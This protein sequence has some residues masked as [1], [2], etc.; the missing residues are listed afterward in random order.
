MRRKLGYLLLILAPAL[1]CGSSSLPTVYAVAGYVLGVPL[2][3]GVELTLI[4]ERASLNRTSS[5]KGQFVFAPVKAGVYTLTPTLAGYSFSPHD[6][7]V[8]LV[9]GQDLFDQDFVA[10]S[11]NLR[12]IAGQVSGVVVSG[13]QIDLG[14]T[15]T[16]ST[17]T[18]AGGAFRFDA[19][20]EGTD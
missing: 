2:G 20:A 6:R 11:L 17:V 19:L 8:V 10:T 5:A 18:D 13:V 7:T 12:A 3:E 9:G 14:G 15:S 1:G 16:R 4:G